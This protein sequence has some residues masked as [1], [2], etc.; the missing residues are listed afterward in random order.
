VTTVAAGVG[1]AQ[2]T[3]A[4]PQ[5]ERKPTVYLIGDSTVRNGSLDNGATAGQWG[6]GHILHY[7]F[8]ESRIKIVNDAMGGTSSRSYLESPTLWALVLPRIQKGDYVLIQFGHNDSPA[9]LR[10]NGD[11][12]GEKAGARGGPAVMV[13]SYGW[14]I[15]QYIKQIKEKGATPIVCSLIPRNRWTGDKV[16]RN[17]ADYALWAKEAAEQE[18]VPFIPLN[19]LIADE[20]DKLG[21]EKVT[22][23]FFPPNE[24]VHPN[25][26]GAKFNAERVVEGIKKLEN[27]DLK[28]YLAVHPKAPDEPDIK[29]PAHGELGPEG[30]AVLTRRRGG[31]ATRPATQPNLP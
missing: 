20:Y 28:L 6:W 5:G 14:Y 13:H 31:A 10:G 11:E 7:Y 30:E 9:T 29:P 4:S 8:D 17:D 12:T 16:N 3:P 18:K 23:E 19:T 26:A 21:K 2:N 27:T 1:F 22:A 24:A 15:R 25:W